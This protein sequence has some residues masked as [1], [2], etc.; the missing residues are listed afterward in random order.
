MEIE[1]N[2]DTNDELSSD[3]MEI[4]E[5]VEPET[6]IIG[7]NCDGSFRVLMKNAHVEL[8]LGYVQMKQNFPKLLAKYNFQNY[9]DI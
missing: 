2:L 8:Q 1:S 5:Y 6:I 3:E 7:R 9:F 4:D